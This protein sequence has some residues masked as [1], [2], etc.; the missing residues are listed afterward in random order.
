MINLGII[1]MGIRGQMYANAIL[2]SSSARL[3]SMAEP[4]EKVLAQC[5]SQYGGKGYRDYKEMLEEEV[6]DAVIIATPDFMHF[7]MV[8]EAVRKGIHILVEKPFAT[9]GDQARDMLDI[10]EESGVKC[11]VGFENRWNLPF[12]N[13]KNAVEQGEIGRIITLNTRLNDTIY[14]PTKMLSWAERTTPA[15]FLLSHSIDMSC[16]LTGKKAVKVQATGIKEKLVSMGIDTYDS[17]AAML[18]FEDGT[19]GTYTTSWVLPESMPMVY[20]FK[21]EIIGTEGAMYVDLQDQMVYQGGK[22]YTHRHVL[23]TPVA[24]RLTAAP[25]MMLYEFIDNIVQDT[26]PSSDAYAGYANTI[27]VEAIHRS[28][29]DE[30]MVDI[31]Y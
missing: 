10:I 8:K 23:G 26:Y 21:Y 9:S 15:W 28:I 30:C 1:G 24:G 5:V 2:H 31:T 20:D 4:I 27:I 3:I 29:E 19:I 22:V 18:T 25:E 7:D 11:M 14:V 6:L 12:V 17:I 16:W 13:V